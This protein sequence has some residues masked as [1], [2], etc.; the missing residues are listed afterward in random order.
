MAEHP[1]FSGESQKADRAGIRP[2]IFSLGIYASEKLRAVLFFAGV[3]LR[4]AWYGLELFCWCNF[5]R[6]DGSRLAGAREIIRDA[7][8]RREQT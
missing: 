1:V 7:Q 4:L 3:F 2:R 8:R 6:R 5:L